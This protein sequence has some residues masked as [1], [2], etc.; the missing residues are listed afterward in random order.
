MSRKVVLDK[1]S[2]NRERPVTKA[3]KF[4]SCTRKSCCF[5][6]HLNWNGLCEK[7]CIQRE[8]ITGMVAGYHKTTTKTTNKEQNKTQTNKIKNGKQSGY[9]KNKPVFDWQPVKC[10]RLWSN[11]LMSSLAKTTF[12]ARLGMFCRLYI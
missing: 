6:P 8:A 1:G 11:M 5:S 2:L 3:L 4:P 12:A 9:L 10:L 7:E